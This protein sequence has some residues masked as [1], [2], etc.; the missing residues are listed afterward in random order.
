MG[1]T[2][3][4]TPNTVQRDAVRWLTGDT[5]TADQQITDEEVTYAIAQAPNTYM[6]AA[7]VA[8][9]L[10]A[11]Y[12]R[13]ADRTVG[14]ISLRSSQQ[15]DAYR[16]L[17][18]R[19]RNQASTAAAVKPYAGGISQDDKEAVEDDEDRALPSF[20]RAL[21]GHPDLVGATTEDD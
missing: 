16:E 18:T 12:S 7:L 17:A 11:K 4:N 3:S 5:D 19:L 21:H 13:K 2:Y 6:A 9:A 1:W 14:D 15:A 8:E 10:A 20:T